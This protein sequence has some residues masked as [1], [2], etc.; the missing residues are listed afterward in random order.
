MTFLKMEGSLQMFSRTGE[1]LEVCAGSIEA[2]RV[3]GQL[4]NV[5]VDPTGFDL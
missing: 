5:P 1:T 3:F 2:H 4:G